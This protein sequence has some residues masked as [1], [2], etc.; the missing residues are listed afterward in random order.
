MA[1]VYFACAC[2]KIMTVN[3]L[4]VTCKVCCPE[5]G[6]SLLAPSP[7][8]YWRCACGEAMAAPKNL[9][10]VSV[11]CATCAAEHKVPICL[12]LKR[13][14][15]PR[16]AAVPVFPVGRQNDL[17]CPKC[18]YICAAILTR[19]PQ[20]QNCLHKWLT[21]SHQSV[22][23][24]KIILIIGLGW[25]LAAN[26]SSIKGWLQGWRTAGNLS[27]VSTSGPLPD[28]ANVPKTTAPVPAARP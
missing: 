17:R 21:I 12:G 13:D 9:A 22:R 16:D 24:A 3:T 18:G 28:S 8:I 23:A 20:C 1:S 10:G 15:Q 11:R 14:A 6:R 5:C 7:A 2:S 19:C 27:A 25:L 4:S 26:F